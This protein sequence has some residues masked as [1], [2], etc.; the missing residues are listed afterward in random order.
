MITRTIK[1]ETDCFC[2]VALQSC[3]MTNLLLCHPKILCYIF[4][5]CRTR[6]RYI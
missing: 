4:N 5:D 1:G 2:R 6:I 3:N